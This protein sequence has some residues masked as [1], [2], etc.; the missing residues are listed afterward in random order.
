MRDGCAGRMGSHE[1]YVKRKS[2]LF[3]GDQFLSE[4]CCC[5]ATLLKD[6]WMGGEELVRVLP[7]WL[8]PSP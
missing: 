3:Y 2:E 4:G 6:T 7:Y 5:H 8:T 1:C